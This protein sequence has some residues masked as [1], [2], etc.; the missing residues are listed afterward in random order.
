V[1]AQWKGVVI[2]K[3][4]QGQ[5]RINRITYEIC[6]LRPCAIRL[7]CR[8][9]WVVGANRYRNPDDD[10]PADF[11]NKRTE[12]YQAL[13]LPLDPDHFIKNLQAEMHTALEAFN[14]GLP[15]NK[16]VRI[17]NKAGGWIT[18]TPFEPQPEPVNLI[19]LKAEITATG[20]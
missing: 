16:K 6:V 17:S 7:R 10:L 3:D 19:S 12:Y 20:R 14:S 5:P 1:R 15:D 18:V 13:N 4:A 2:E 8:E 9:I 11:E